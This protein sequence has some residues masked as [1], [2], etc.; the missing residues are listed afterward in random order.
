M[1]YRKLTLNKPPLRLLLQSFDALA[2]KIAEIKPRVRLG[3]NSS[4]YRSSLKLSV[5]GVVRVRI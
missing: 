4:V 3:V 2:R 5:C 1:S